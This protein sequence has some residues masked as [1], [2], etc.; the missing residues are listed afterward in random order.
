MKRILDASLA[1]TVFSIFLLNTPAAEAA[2]EKVIYSFTAVLGEDGAAPH[3]GL[4]HANGL[5]YGTTDY[6]GTLFSIDPKTG[7]ET[8][9]HFFKNSPDGLFPLAG[10][11][12]VKGT[13]YGTTSLGGTGGCGEGCGTV[14]AL[15]PSTG[16]EAV[17][18]S[19]AGGADGDLPMADLIYIKG[20]LYGTTYTGGAG[21]CQT[22]VGLGCGTVFSVDPTTGVEKVL[23]TFQYGM[24]DGANPYGGLVDV[25][26]TLYGTTAYGGVPHTGCHGGCGTI[27]SIDRTTGAET[28]VYSF[29]GGSRGANPEAGLTYVSGKLYGTTAYG[30]DVTDCTGYDPGCGTVFEFNPSTGAERLLYSF[31]G[32]GNPAAAVLHVKGL[33]YGTTSSG[34][35]CCGTVFSFNLKTRAEALLYSFKDRPD[36]ASPAAP[37]TNVNGTLY[38]TTYYGGTSGHGA[39]FSITP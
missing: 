14:F 2:A 24:S 28:L 21:G 12:D 39:V 34:S 8:V 25:N 36:G 33:L 19:F 27:F 11:I 9:L 20:K 22:L 13:L 37:L 6:P 18:Y 16:A 1:C 10:V 5:L 17:L 31:T 29:R 30:G 26:G 3:A 32:D 38:G 7:A 35:G 15:N 23:H 4:L